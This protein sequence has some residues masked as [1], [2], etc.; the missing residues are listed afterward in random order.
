[1]ENEKYYQ[2]KWFAIL[3]L[4]FFAPVGIFLIYK[5]G[6][7]KQKTN[8]VLSIIFGLFFLSVAINGY[9]EETSSEN[10]KEKTEPVSV[11]VTKTEHEIK[12]EKLAAEEKAKNDEAAKKLKDEAVKKKKEEDAANKERTKATYIADTK[13]NID[14]AI[15]AYDKLWSAYWVPTFDAMAL[16]NYNRYQAYD[17]MTNLAKQY[18]NLTM[19]SVNIPDE[20]SKADKKNLKEFKSDLSTAAMIRKE[21]AT[22]AASMI[23]KNDFS[24]STMNKIKDK[25]SQS[26]AFMVSALANL[27]VFELKYEIER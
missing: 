27:T 13:P 10:P 6:H 8:L 3:L 5:Y 9:S 17:N 7:F 20:M 19:F 11:D 26:D 25:V 21:T 22:L 15:S 24:P 12:I 14:K 4:I 2:E 23:D 16:G 18:E 1:M